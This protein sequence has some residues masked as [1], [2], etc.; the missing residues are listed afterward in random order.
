MNIHAPGTL[1]STP[2]CQCHTNISTTMP[3][4]GTKCHHIFHLNIIISYKKAC[5]YHG[6]FAASKMNMEACTTERQRRRNDEADEDI[7]DEH[8]AFINATNF[9]VEN[10][11]VGI[12]LDV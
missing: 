2:S 1:N 12:V 9:I 5:L 10:P 6:R 7:D 11:H 3:A 4:N 8:S